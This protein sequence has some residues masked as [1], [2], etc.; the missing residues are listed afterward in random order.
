MG[1][2]PPRFRWFE[3]PAGARERREP[4]PHILD[5][6]RR[7]HY[8]QSDCTKPGHAAH[9][10]VGVGSCRISRAGFLCRLQDAGDEARRR[11]YALFITNSITACQM[12][13]TLCDQAGQSRRRRHLYHHVRTRY[14]KHTLTCGAAARAVRHGGTEPT[15]ST[16]TKSRS[17]TS[18]ADIHTVPVRPRSPPD[19][20][21]STPPNTGCARLNGW[22]ARTWREGLKLIIACADQRLLH[23][24]AYLQLSS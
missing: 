14:S 22:A 17:T 5:V 15:R 21:W 11:G 16:A 4:S 9:A 10:D 7:E 19:R 2:R 18:L 13:R 8:T 23:S 3:R 1:C 6:A 12:T 20:A 24:D